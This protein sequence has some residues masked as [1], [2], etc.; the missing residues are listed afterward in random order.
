MSNISKDFVTKNGVVVKGTSIVTGLTSQTNALQVDGGASIQKN[1]IVGSTATIYGPTNLLNTA[2]SLNTG[3]GAL[4]VSGGVGIGRDLNVG[5]DIY[6][7]NIFGTITTATNLANG[8]AGQLPYQAAPGVTAFHGPGTAGEILVSAGTSGPQYTNT[9]SIYVGFANQSNNLLGG[10]VG[11][12]P[13]QSAANTTTFLSI[14]SNYSILSSDGSLPSWTVNPT[15]GGDLTVLGNLTVQGTAT[16]VD[17]TVTN[18]VD[19]ILTIGAGPGGSPPEPG[20]QK[21]RGIAFVWTGTQAG[22][23]TSR[24]GFFGFDRSSGFFTFVTSATLTNEIVEPAGGTERGAID[25]NLA[26]GNQGEIPIQSAPDKTAFIAAATQDGHV[27]TWSTA[28]S[29]ATWRTLS[30]SVID[31]ANT[32]THL[33]DG[34][35]GEIPYQTAPGRTSFIGTGS[36]YNIL[37]MGTAGT[38]TFVATTTIQVGF[39]VNILGGAANQVPYQSAGNATTFSPNLTYNGTTF[40]AT[41]IVVSNPTNAINATSGA[42]QVVGGV[43]IAQDLWV[44]GASN[45]T[46]ISFTSATGTTATLVNINASG[47]FLGNRILGSVITATQYLH[48]T[49]T[50]NDVASYGR[51]LDP[52][53]EAV[54]VAGAIHALGN[55]SVGGVLYAGMNDSGDVAGQN[56][57]NKTINGVFVANSMI[58]GGTYDNITTTTTQTIDSFNTSSYTSAKYIVQITDSGRIHTQEIMLIH[59]GANIY[60]S[61]YG[62]VTNAGQLGTFSGTITGS[63]VLLNFTANS[64]TNMTVN[65]V[66]HSIIPGLQPYG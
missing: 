22:L 31:F 6:A 18:I 4:V 3:S 37:Q 62:I 12:L 23:D 66:R 8:T 24:T 61:Q 57:R 2:N 41:E 55:V 29:S 33:K 44:G 40:T 10:A 50:T 49:T 65:L 63:A 51:N 21:D 11:S 17:S 34:L 54:G 14:G 1:L 20:D 53:R 25:A 47:N 46:T 15:I 43:G 32:A 45:F 52:S 58:A 48:V 9:T 27:L 64:A 36:Q 19:P 60:M 26:R 39:A 13:Y 35:R 28:T 59:N 56:P 16:I 38:A 7:S 30:A 5:G 42:L